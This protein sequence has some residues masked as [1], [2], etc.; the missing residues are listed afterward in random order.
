MAKNAKKETEELSK[1]KSKRTERRKEVAKEKRHKL[2]SRIIGI[3]ISA[4]AIGALAVIIVFQVYKAAIRTTSSSDFSN[5]L[6][7][8]GLIDGVN[9]Q[10]YITLADYESLVIPMEEVAATDDEVNADINA[11]LESYTELVE[12]NTLTIA[13]GDEVN[14]DY[15]GTID[16]E[17]FDGGNSNGE[18]YDL[19]IGSGTFID[20]FEEQLIGH[21]PGEEVTVEVTFPD[22]YSNAD[23]AGKDA[24]FAVTIHGIYIVPELTDELVQEY[25]SDIASSASEY[26]AYVENSYYEEHL[27]DYLDNYIIDNSTV[28]SYPKNYLKILKSLIKYNDEYTL[29]YYNQMFAQYG[30]STYENVWETRDGIENETDYEHELTTR[31]KDSAKDALVYQAI[32]VKAGLTMDMDAYLEEIAAENGEDTVTTMKET[33][34]IGYMAQARIKEL[35]ID[36]LMENAVVE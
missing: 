1:S 7:D 33:Y 29:N 10:D 15:V 28:N 5:G 6:T 27:E 13:D 26:R 31:A 34:G 16:G 22:D 3:V 30:V 2:V 35:V 17:E 18:G 23:L 20:D 14:I 11:S 25:F 21:K 24:S 4:A 19:T 32:F 9:A 36:Y 12:D 8:E